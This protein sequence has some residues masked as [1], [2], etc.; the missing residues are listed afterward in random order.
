ML[1]RFADGATLLRDAERSRQRACRRQD[2]AVARH[3]GE[4]RPTRDT[5]Q[6]HSIVVCGYLDFRSVCRLHNPS[7]SCRCTLLPML[8]LLLNRKNAA[9]AELLESAR[10]PQWRVVAV[11]VVVV[12]ASRRVRQCA[13]VEFNERRRGHYRRIE[14][15]IY[16]VRQQERD[17]KL[18]VFYSVFQPERTK[19]LAHTEPD[20]TVVISVVVQENRALPA[21]ATAHSVSLSLREDRERQ[22]ARQCE[23]RQ[24]CDAL[25]DMRLTR[26]RRPAERSVQPL[27][28][29]QRRRKHTDRVVTLH[30]FK[31][32]HSNTLATVGRAIR[33]VLGH[34][35]ERIAANEL[36]YVAQIDD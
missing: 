22:V 18:V 1:R 23:I 19:R 3:H 29:R 2:A 24:R 35:A 17:A 12:D 16:G 21:V 15:H 11:V 8:S 14:Q 28:I 7:Y 33:A 26:R 27:S 9:R 6:E 5:H 10:D 36:Q 13:Q 34:L 30:R 32:E 4:H 31:L 25:P 20:T